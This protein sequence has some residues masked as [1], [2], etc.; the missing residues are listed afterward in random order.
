MAE[1]QPPRNGAGSPR[2]RKHDLGCVPDQICGHNQPSRDRESHE[3]ASPPLARQHDNT[4]DETHESKCHQLHNVGSNPDFKWHLAESLVGQVLGGVSPEPDSGFKRV[5]LPP[6]SGQRATLLLVLK[7]LNSIN[8]RSVSS[9]PCDHPRSEQG[10]WGRLDRLAP[11]ARQR[12]LKVRPGDAGR[13]LRSL[14]RRRRRVHGI[15]Q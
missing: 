2:A 11:E 3:P 12:K 13:R 5:I 4:N 7:G 6:C 14:L 9:S 15:C 8:R 10:S 1:T